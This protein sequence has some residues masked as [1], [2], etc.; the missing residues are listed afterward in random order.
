VT[1]P[2]DQICPIC[3]A[4]QNIIA[5]LNTASPNGTIALGFRV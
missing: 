3:E 5:A 1:K 4:V 2:C